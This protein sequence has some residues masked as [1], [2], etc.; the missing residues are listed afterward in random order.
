LAELAFIY[1]VRELVKKFNKEHKLFDSG[2]NFELED[3][4]IVF[5]LNFLEVN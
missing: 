4:D 2:L 3:F 5:A 1:A